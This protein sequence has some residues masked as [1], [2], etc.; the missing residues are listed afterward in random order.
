MQSAGIMVDTY[1]SHADVCDLLRQKRW[2]ASDR[3]NTAGRSRS[4]YAKM[5]PLF[6]SV[7]RDE[8]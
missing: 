7:C 6:R 2:L 3:E 4:C 1:V 8:S 5:M